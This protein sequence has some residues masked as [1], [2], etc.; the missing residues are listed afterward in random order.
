M[1]LHLGCLE[2]ASL[3]YHPC[4]LLVRLENIRAQ[5]TSPDIHPIVPRIET[6]RVGGREDIIMKEELGDTA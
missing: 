1:L 2:I 6:P 4:R 3:Q 5:V